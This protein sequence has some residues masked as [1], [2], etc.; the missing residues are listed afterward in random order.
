[1]RPWAFALALIW[2]PQAHAD[3]G[4]RAPR[5][6]PLPEAIAAFCASTAAD[7]SQLR[8]GLAAAIDAQD[9]LS[10]DHLAEMLG[11]L[12]ADCR[13]RVVCAV[14]G[15]DLANRDNAI[16]LTSTLRR[17]SPSWSDLDRACVLSA[18]DRLSPDAAEM[19]VAALGDRSE[20]VRARARDL[21]RGRGVGWVPLVQAS[22]AREGW[23]GTASGV[24][25]LGAV[26]APAQVAVLAESNLRA[27]ELPVRLEA[28][29]LL[30][31]MNRW[32]SEVA[33]V[34]AEGF[35]A[36]D[37]E[38]RRRTVMFS[39]TAPEQY[40][41]RFLPLWVARLA[42]S[43]ALVSNEAIGVLRE[44][45]GLDRTAQRQ[46]ERLLVRGGL[47]RE[48]AL[49]L[50][51][52]ERALDPAI[53]VEVRALAGSEDPQE[54]VAAA[55]LLSRARVHPEWGGDVLRSLAADA[56]REV[57]AEARRGVA[58]EGGATHLR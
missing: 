45:V 11:D 47:S 13:S 29:F 6:T 53:E 34:I 16:A 50:E 31:Q 1:M 55:R 49:A 51:G 42:D 9:S 39:G 8:R 56:D 25:L 36:E 54:R 21:L 7:A 19:L 46:V 32:T 23:A 3:G 52:A 12:S 58:Q 35:D 38:V 17:A 43:D 44:A 10:R 26:L 41:I 27:A 57:A 37:R 18:L 40:L 4:D 28:A 15:L 14:A 5:L 33:L 2:V 20:F 48:A 30:A 24:R 22:M